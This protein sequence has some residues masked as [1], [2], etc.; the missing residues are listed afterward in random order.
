[1]W[2]LIFGDDLKF[3]SFFKMKPWIYKESAHLKNYI[4]SI[5]TNKKMW[6]I[7]ENLNIF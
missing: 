4:Y 2:I 1:M 7:G 5:M 6:C 3:W